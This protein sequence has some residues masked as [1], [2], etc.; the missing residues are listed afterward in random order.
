MLRMSCL[1]TYY[2]QLPMGVKTASTVNTSIFIQPTSRNW[3]N[4]GTVLTPQAAGQLFKK[5]LTP[6]AARSST[7]AAQD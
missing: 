6:Q 1:E 7:Q 5:G 3:G 2:Y 4:I